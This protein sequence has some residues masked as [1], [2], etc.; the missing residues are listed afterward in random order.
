MKWELCVDFFG[1]YEIVWIAY[2]CS[3]GN[4][5]ISL[6]CEQWHRYLIIREGGV[7]CLHFIKIQCWIKTV[8]TISDLDKY[9]KIFL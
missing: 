5:S 6:N 2:T 7:L 8:E 1:V 4:V 9:D 3:E